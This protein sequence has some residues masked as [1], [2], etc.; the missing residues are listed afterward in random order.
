[1]LTPLKYRLI[2]QGKGCVSHLTNKEKER[3]D[4]ERE[5]LAADGVVISGLV[6]V[7]VEESGWRVCELRLVLP[8]GEGEEGKR[9]KGPIKLKKVPS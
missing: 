6:P 9:Q 8:E 1:M 4:R 7:R 3:A 5:L 2:Y